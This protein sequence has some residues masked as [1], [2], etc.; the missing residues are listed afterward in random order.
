[1]SL[2]NN[3]LIALLDTILDTRIGAAGLN[4]FFNALTGN[5]GVL[6]I[7]NITKAAMTVTLPFGSITLGISELI[8]S[9]LDSWG[10]FD[11]FHPIDNFTMSSR[12]DMRMLALNATFFINITTAGSLTGGSLYEQAQLSFNITDCTLHAQSQLTMN[13]ATVQSLYGTQFADSA[14][15]R[16][17][18]TGLNIT[19]FVLNTTVQS[20]ELLAIGAE[21]EKDLDQAID[22]LLLLFTLGLQPAIPALLNSIIDGEVR[23]LVNE[24]IYNALN[25]NS[26]AT[27]APARFDAVYD[28][29][30]L[31]YTSMIVVVGTMS[32][33]IFAFMLYRKKS[34]RKDLSDKMPSLNDDATEASPLI[35]REDAYPPALIVHPGLS[36]FWRLSIVALIWISIGLFVFSNSNVGAAVHIVLTIGGKEHVLPSIFEFSLANSV[37]DMWVAGVYPLS[38]IIAIFSG[39]W[40]YLKLLIMQFCWIAPTRLLSTKRR[41]TIFMVVD[42]LGK[43]SLI[44][45]IIMALMIVAFRFSVASQDHQTVMD[46]IVD[47]E[48]GIY[49]FV[50]GTMLSLIVGHL[51]LNLDRSVTYPRDVLNLALSEKEALHNHHFRVEGMLTRFTRLGKA[52]LPALILISTGTMLAGALIESFNFDFQG[53]AALV[54]QL[55]GV[56]PK[57]GYSLLS[58]AEEIPSSAANPH[59]IGVLFLQGVF[60]LF[61]L[62]MPLAHLASM[63]FLWLFPLTLKQQH[64]VFRAVEIFNAWSALD[65]FVLAIIVSLVELG[66][67]AQFMV[68]DSCDTINIILKE[69][70]DHALDGHDTCFTVVATLSQGCWVLFG[71]AFIA[72]VCAITITKTCHGALMERTRQAERRHS[73]AS[74][75][76]EEPSCCSRA[77]GC[78]RAS[79]LCFYIGFVEKESEV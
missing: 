74:G 11:L 44:D 48:I 16:E 45:T 52:I 49:T 21:L 70:F 76:K 32:C 58:L 56:S 34:D 6:R 7:P 40:P 28:E 79:L 41:E 50:C 72:V 12:S 67:F 66:Q 54:L 8:I 22:N 30:S 39:T 25:L 59:S 33:I 19:Q 13:Q 75:D 23:G 24:K 29:L 69:Y 61:T 37:H 55:V 71:A 62:G 15:L 3:N 10:N 5:T 38:L 64:V 63:L 60:I 68:G 20:I 65:V 26:T 57:R 27:C 51:C 17:A 77:C 78:A 73:I 36:L 46:V 43:W 1:M 9:G 2:F 42:A 47:P 18:V 4:H 14:C 53:A 31:V 35:S